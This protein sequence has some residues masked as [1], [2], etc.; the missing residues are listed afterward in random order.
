M[1]EPVQLAPLLAIYEDDGDYT[2]RVGDGAHARSLSQPLVKL[3]GDLGGAR[4]LTFITPMDTRVFKLGGSNGSSANGQENSSANGELRGHEPVQYERTEPR[5]LPPR[6]VR[7]RISQDW[8]APPSPELV[9]ELEQDEAGREA[10]EALRQEQQDALEVRAQQRLMAQEPT[11]ADT[12]PPEIPEPPQRR[13]RQPRQSP[14]ANATCGRCQG[15]KI[16]EGGGTCPV[17]R[18][19]GSTYKWGTK[20]ART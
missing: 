2:I 6:P 19:E 5:P 8:A 13:Q 3:I 4:K 16:I 10:A 7:E 20:R 18:G 12:P 9:A 11:P 15:A 17:C 1:S 14:V